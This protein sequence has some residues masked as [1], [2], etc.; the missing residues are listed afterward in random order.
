MR[1]PSAAGRKRSIQCNRRVVTGT[2]AL[3]QCRQGRSG[4]RHH[5]SP[6]AQKHEDTRDIAHALPQWCSQG[7]AKVGGNSQSNRGQHRKYRQCRKNERGGQRRRQ[8]KHNSGN[9]QAR[10][11]PIGGG[12]LSVMALTPP[13]RISG[14]KLCRHGG[15]SLGRMAATP[16]KRGRRPLRRCLQ[17]LA[18]ARELKIRNDRGVNLRG[19]G[20]D[21]TS[22]KA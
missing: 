15:H 14:R 16:S 10:Q 1:Q 11:S 18:H 5:R 2:C 3:I 17:V 22:I 20:D 13:C 4:I 9:A 19:H 8:A 21:P 12:Q 6:K 7:D